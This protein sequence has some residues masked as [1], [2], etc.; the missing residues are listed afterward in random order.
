[1]TDQTTEVPDDGT[2]PSFSRAPVGAMLGVVAACLSSVGT[3]WIG[4]LMALVVADVLGRNFLNAPITGV[5]EIAGRSVVA[6]VFLQVSAAVLQKRLTRADFLLRAIGGGNP[7]G[8]HVLECAFA[9]TGAVVFALVLWASWP[10]TWEALATGEFFGVQG[11]FT[12]PTFPFRLI[13]VVGAGLASLCSLYRAACEIRA[14]KGG[15]V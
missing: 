7:R 11:V 1:M 9:L 8:A 12:I 4:G 14:L 10:K 2:I 13:T 3:L 5:S 15:G 6:I